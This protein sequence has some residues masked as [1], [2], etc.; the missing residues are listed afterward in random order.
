M[1]VRRAEAG[2]AVVGANIRVHRLARR[3]SQSALAGAL[4]LSFQQLQK[5]ESGANR[6]GAARLVR[7]AAALRVPATALLKGVAQGKGDAPSPAA[8]IAHRHPLP[9]IQAFAGIKDRRLRPA[10][11]AL[12]EGIARAVRGA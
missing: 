8:L 10:L 12:T 5:Y 4:G 1:S 6:V 3:M 11:I 9:L 7:I 2:D